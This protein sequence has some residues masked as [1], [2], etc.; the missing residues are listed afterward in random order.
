MLCSVRQQIELLVSRR[1]VSALRFQQINRASAPLAFRTAG[2]T[3]SR[4]APEFGMLTLTT[5]ISL[6]VVD[7]NILNKIEYEGFVLSALTW[8]KPR[9]CADPA[10]FFE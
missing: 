8:I 1:N 5:S 10:R 3:A 9:S 4:D 6:R 2:K 7:V